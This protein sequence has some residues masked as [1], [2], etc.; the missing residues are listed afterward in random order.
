[1]K[2]EELPDGGIKCTMEMPEWML[3][4]S[5]EEL[6]TLSECIQAELEKAMEEQM[7]RVFGEGMLTPLEEK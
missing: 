2:V 7:K 5:D 3:E 1:M 6:E 4:L